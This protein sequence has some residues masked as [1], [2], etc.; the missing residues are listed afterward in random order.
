HRA[1]AAEA[2][3]HA[4][5]YGL[6]DQIAALHWVQA[7]I[8]QFGGDPAQVTIFGESAGAQDVGQMLASPQTTGLFA[9]AIAQSGT[10]S[11]GLPW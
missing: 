7:H 4:G 5:N 6:M 11:F 2:G 8:A 10:P 1:A 9:R 3:G